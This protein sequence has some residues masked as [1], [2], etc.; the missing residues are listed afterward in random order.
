MRK[1]LIALFILVFLNSSIAPAAVYAYPK[2]P[3]FLFEVGLSF[4]KQGRYEDALH[5]FKKALRVQ[6]DYEPALKYIRLI[7]VKKKLIKEKKPS[8]GTLS[9]VPDFLFETGK[10][11]YQQGKY[12]QALGAFQKALAIKPDYAPA[13]QYIELLKNKGL[14]VKEIPVILPAETAPEYAIAVPPAKTK[15]RRETPQKQVKYASFKPAATTA[16]GAIKETLELFALQQEMI[17]R[18]MPVGL[19]EEEGAEKAA[20]PVIIRLD[21]DFAKIPQ[22]IEI[23]QGS[24][25]TVIGRNIQRF[26]VVQPDILGVEKKSPDELSATGKDLGYTYLHIWDNN[27]RWTIEFLTGLPQAEGPSYE[28]LMRKEEEKARNFRLN[29]DLT[30]SSFESGRRFDSLRRSSYSWGHRLALTGETPYGV[31]DSNVNIRSLGKTTDMTYFTF[32]LT[33]GK[34]GPF[35]DFIIRGFD[36]S[37][38]SSNLSFPGASMRGAMLSSPA[39]N[40]KIKYATFW[41]REGGGR[42]GNLSPGLTKIKNSF[43]SGAN[44]TFTPTKRQQYGGSVVRG[45]GRDR[46]TYL[47]HWGYDLSTKWDLDRFG[48]DYEIA[49]DTER[50]AHLF[51]SYY[52]RPKMNFTAQFRN[53]DQNFYNMVGRGWA[54]GEFGGLFNLNFQTTDKL[55][56]TNTL[57]V[58]QD[59]LFPRPGEDDLWNENYDWS[60]NYKIDPTTTLIASYALQNQLAKISP[61]R[62][63]NEGLSI[64]KRSKLLKDLYLY[65]NYYH[66]QNDNFSAPSLSYV[67][68]KLIAGIRFGLIGNLFYYWNSE[69]NRLNDKTGKITYPRANETGLDWT[70]QF[71][72]APLFATMRFS[73]RDEEDATSTLSF[74]SGQDYVDGYLELSYRPSATNEVYG[75]CHVRNIWADRDTINK[76]IDADFNAGIRYQWDTGIAW[77]SVGNVEGYVFKDLNSDGLRQRDEAPAEGI[78]IWLGRDKSQLTDLFGYY[79]FKGVRARTAYVTLDA[80]TLP[81]GFVLT[82]PVTQEAPIIHHRTAEIDFGMVS[83]SEIIGF[84]FEDTNGDGEYNE[85]GKG[86]QGVTITLENGMKA[87]TDASGRYAFPNVPT[88][89][90]TITMELASLPVYYLPQAALTKSFELFEGVSYLHNIPVKR[91]QE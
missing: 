51:H 7:E 43:L 80:S 18:Q 48:F 78:K 89:E 1:S 70:G 64:S 50:F 81:A 65:A 61:T 28:E 12:E 44:A 8:A 3:E 54:A 46:P 23:Q 72:R 21:D 79:R 52:N 90:H 67:N 73:Y 17:A 69:F 31:F 85:M 75:S 59:R 29:Y 39:F 41:G 35:R 77:E 20:A 86:V 84:V 2:A 19:P 45:W 37:A 68:D 57:D 33:D 60:A 25:I 62:Y 87:I 56:M 9:A 82:V 55:S 49:Y 13:Q 42:Y 58:W 34:W 6:A 27:G 83:R 10:K 71:T 22:P 4:Y 11:Y 30:W 47:H 5:E 24:S 53:I 16:S 38:P 14:E 66:Q 40:K 26:L 63:Q 36:Y 88:G 76:R 15:A 32:G 91:V 74:L